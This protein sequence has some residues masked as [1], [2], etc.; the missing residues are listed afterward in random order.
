MLR[1]RLSQAGKKTKG[2]AVQ[3]FVRLCPYFPY[4]AQ[5]AKDIPAGVIP[6]ISLEDIIVFKLWSCHHRETSPNAA[7]DVEEAVDLLDAVPRP[8]ALSQQQ[9]AIIADVISYA[10]LYILEDRR[11]WLRN[12]LDLKSLNPTNY[13]NG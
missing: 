9:P 6:Y 11:D 3:F 8:L 7:K 12:R 2:V 5:R 1:P 4:A 13:E 10:M